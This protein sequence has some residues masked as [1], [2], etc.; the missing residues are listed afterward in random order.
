[1]IFTLQSKQDKQLEQFYNEVMEELGQFFGF[2][3]LLQ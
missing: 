2:N 1:M 3:W